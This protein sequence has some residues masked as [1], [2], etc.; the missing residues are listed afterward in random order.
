MA[1]ALTAARGYFWSF[2]PSPPDDPIADA[3]PST[4]RYALH[5]SWFFFDGGV[6]FNFSHSAF[7]S[8]PPVVAFSEAMSGLLTG[9]SSDGVSSALFVS[10]G[11]GNFYS[12]G[13][14]L[15]FLDVTLT[16]PPLIHEQWYNLIISVDSVTSTVQAVLNGSAMT[17][18]ATDIRNTTSMAQPTGDNASGNPIQLWAGSL[19]NPGCVADAYWHTPAAFFDLTNP[20]NVAKF[21]D[22]GGNPVDLGADASSVV[23]TTP[24]IYLTIR[25]GGSDFMDFNTNRGT[26]GGTVYVPFSGLNDWCT[27]PSPP[28]PSGPRGYTL[29]Y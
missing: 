17:V 27:A 7:N 3:Y 2:Q 18:T 1:Y 24:L 23:G 28:G 10:C 8:N 29:V 5:S 16:G 15:T 19:G 4:F 9:L 11:D 25:P 26:A 6:D 21:I 12:P 22:L 14:Q 13:T 20:S